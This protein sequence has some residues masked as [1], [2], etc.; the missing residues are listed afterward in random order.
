MATFIINDEKKLNSYGFRVRNEGIDLARFKKNPV[1]LEDHWNSNSSV[2][3]RWKNIRTEGSKMMADAEFDLEDD[4][5]VKISGKV[6]RGF[7]KGCSMGVTFDR[8]LMKKNN[9]GTQNL[10]ECELL[11][12]SLVAVPSNANALTLFAKTG[13]VLEAAEVKLSLQQL[14]S[15]IKTKKS[16]M[17][18]YVLSAPALTALGLASADDANAVSTAIVEM[19]SKLQKSKTALAAL[20]AEAEKQEGVR[21]EALVDGAITEGKLKADMK[22]DFVSMA[23]SNYALTAKVIA[24]MPTKKSLS[25][26]VKN[27]EASEVKTLDDFEKLSTTEKLAFREDH[28]MEYNKLFV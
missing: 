9:D 15:E 2:I 1:M 26:M 25:A 16:N 17:D 20:E 12:V 7:I 19:E 27:T 10:D 28:L 24:G 14:E 5:A 6:D 23:K 8:D 21:A 11:E 18:K 4:L 22:A 3:G 13:E